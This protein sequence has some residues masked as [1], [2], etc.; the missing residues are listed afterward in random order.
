MRR[1]AGGDESG[2]AVAHLSTAHNSADNRIYRKECTSLHEAGVDVLL[3]ARGPA[4]EGVVPWVEI[5]AFNGR[6]QRMLRGPLSAWRTIARLRP[7]VLHLHDPELIPL[8][9]AWKV[10]R[11]GRVVYDAHEDLPRQVAGKPYLPSWSRRPVAA[12]ARVLESVADRHFDAIVAA[13]PAI[14]RNFANPSVVLVQNFPWLREYPTPV[15]VPGTGSRSACYVGALSRERGSAEM[16]EALRRTTQRVRLEFAGAT[17]PTARADLDAMGA[18]VTDHGLVPA[19]YIPDIVRGAAVGLVLF[20]ALPNH[21]EAQ[22]TKLFEYMAAGRPFVASDFPHWRSL[23]EEHDAGV[24]VDE[25]DPD[26]IAGV[27]DRLIGDEAELIRLGRNGRAALETH[28]T[29][30]SE[31]VGL[32]SLTR[33]LLRGS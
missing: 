28:F 32:V 3:V 26:A 16:T 23:L 9:L 5:P 20:S 10:L 29:F 13:T 24:F 30:E 12:F 7:K 27:L 8:G 15:P 2:I 25:D 6:I 19:Q 31:A 18:Q 22:P 21:L 1:R 14:A 33:D 4:P 11:R 17:T